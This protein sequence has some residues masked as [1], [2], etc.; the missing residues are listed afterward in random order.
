[1]IPIAF[2]Y[3]EWI[4]NDSEHLVLKKDAPK[5]VVDAFD[6]WVSDFKKPFKKGNEE[7]TGIKIDD[8]L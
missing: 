1:M 7:T 3:P 8:L 5:E 6:K 2:K 4:D